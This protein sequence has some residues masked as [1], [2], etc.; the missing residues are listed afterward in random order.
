MHAH[1]AV[2]ECVQDS[3][4]ALLQASEDAQLRD[5]V[6]SNS[7]TT[8]SGCLSDVAGL[9]DV[10]QELQ[11]MY[12]PNSIVKH[13]LAV[14]RKF[15]LQTPLYTHH[16]AMCSTGIVTKCTA[17]VMC[18]HMCH[19]TCKHKVPVQECVLLPLKFPNLFTGLRRPAMTVLLHGP[20][21][22]QNP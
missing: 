8:V 19:V 22:E 12:S 5:R 4:L 15:S 2:A 1:I 10:K 18:V 14:Q 3:L 9:S 16:A 20:P 11:V 6:I 21:G 7:L 17:C 13:S